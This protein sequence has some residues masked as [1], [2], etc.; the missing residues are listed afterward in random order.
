LNR[1]T[2][3]YLD[4][5]KTVY[6]AEPTACNDLTISLPVRQL[7]SSLLA[8]APTFLE[9]DRQGQDY[10]EL[11]KL[12]SVF[13]APRKVAS[14]DRRGRRL[15]SIEQ[16][17][18]HDIPERKEEPRGASIVGRSSQDGGLNHVPNRIPDG[19]SEQVAYPAPAVAGPRDLFLRS[20]CRR[21]GHSHAEVSTRWQPH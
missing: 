18:Q 7:E 11:H 14:K 3:G 6:A 10:S 4:A 16:R 8:V 12:Q 13:L 15:A 2:P 21:S 20:R 19:L 9:D 17:S 1:L 5:V